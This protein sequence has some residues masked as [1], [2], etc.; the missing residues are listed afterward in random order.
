MHLIRQYLNQIIE[1]SDEDWDVFSSKI[2]KSSFSKKTI[3]LKTGEI[4]NHLSFIEEGAVRIYVPSEK[5]DITLEFS[6]ENQFTSSYISFITQTKSKHQVETLM[7]TTLWRL[8]FSDLQ[9]IYNNTKVGNIIGRKIAENLY[10]LR[11]LR[12][13]SLLHDTAKVRYLKLFTEQPHLIKKIPL[14][15]LASY[16]GITPQALSR[17]RKQIS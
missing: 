9:D 2:K 14:K 5:N 6:F 1:L 10:T 17:I 12:E 8:T 13:R 11:V 3:L 15:Y 16:I 7:P 4:E